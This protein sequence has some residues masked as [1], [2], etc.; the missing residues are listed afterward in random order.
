MHRL[1]I[2]FE[3]VPASHGLR[4]GELGDWEVDL[5]VLRLWTADTNE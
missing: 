4:I 5:D 2:H 3:S 1:Y